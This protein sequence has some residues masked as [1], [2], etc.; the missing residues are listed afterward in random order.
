MSRVSKIGNLPI[1]GIADRDKQGSVLKDMGVSPE[2]LKSRGRLRARHR[3]A[4]HRVALNG[5][6]ESK[7]NDAGPIAAAPAGIMYLDC[8]TEAVHKPN[9]FVLSFGRTR[10]Q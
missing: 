4:L 1:Q 7:Q 6:R 2:T 8:S 3:C 9:A 5:N 10:P